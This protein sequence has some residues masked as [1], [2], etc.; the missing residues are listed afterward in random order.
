[1]LVL[2][3]GWTLTN[4]LQKSSLRSIKI[5]IEQLYKKCTLILKFYFIH[6]HGEHQTGHISKLSVSH[7][8]LLS[9]RMLT[10]DRIL[11][12]EIWARSEMLRTTSGL[13]PERALGLVIVRSKCLYLGCYGIVWITV[14]VY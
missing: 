14:S 12:D 10:S 7:P 13:G 1:M 8:G 6:I 11:S 3:R 9:P 4:Y 2:P 5:V